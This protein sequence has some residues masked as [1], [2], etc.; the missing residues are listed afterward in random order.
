MKKVILILAVVFTGCK[1]QH[2]VTY[3]D[4]QIICRDNRINGIGVVV[5][6]SCEYIKFT[7]DGFNYGI[8]HKGNCKYCKE[9]REVK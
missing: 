4:E 1:D 9:R 6:D 5:L 7:T 2:P 3:T 8:T